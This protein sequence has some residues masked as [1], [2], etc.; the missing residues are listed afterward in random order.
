[1]KKQDATLDA[2]FW[3]NAYAAGLVP[4][5]LDYFNLFVAR[6]V[7]DEICYPLDVLEVPSPGPR[8]FRQWLNEGRI[9]VLVLRIY[10][11]VMAH[12]PEARRPSNAAGLGV[13]SGLSVQSKRATRSAL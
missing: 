7:V 11:Q 8:L 4:F 13:A 5:L 2:S 12:E 3:I 6:A 1:M 10:C 9:L